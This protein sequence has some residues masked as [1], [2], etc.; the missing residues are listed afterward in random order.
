MLVLWFL[1]GRDHNV[2]TIATAMNLEQTRSA[3]GNN[4]EFP[5]LGDAVDG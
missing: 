4:N 2:P 5:R 1:G 3:S